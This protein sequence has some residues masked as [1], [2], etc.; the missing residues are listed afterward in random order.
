MTNEE[1]RAVD[2]CLP[3]GLYV[4]FE[5]DGYY[6]LYSIDEGRY[7]DEYGKSRKPEQVLKKAAKYMK[8]FMKEKK[9]DFDESLERME[10][11]LNG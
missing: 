7:I 3:V 4:Y 6:H 11:Y 10:E 5:D 9:K 2:R 8:D 1:L